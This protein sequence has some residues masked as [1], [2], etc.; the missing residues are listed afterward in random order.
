L[1]ERDVEIQVIGIHDG[2]NVELKTKGKY[3]KKND[4]EY[5]EYMDEENIRNHMKIERDAIYLT[6]YTEPPTNMIF[7]EKEKY[8]FNYQTAYGPMEIVMITKEL[9][10]KCEGYNYDIYIKYDM[11]V[12]GEM[13]EKELRMVVR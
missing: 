8:E 7:K 5:L 12:A 1:V 11:A 2:Q 10:T 9:E 13:M 4:S 3:V 6:K